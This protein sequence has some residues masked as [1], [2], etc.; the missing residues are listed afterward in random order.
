[1]QPYNGRIFKKALGG[2]KRMIYSGHQLSFFPWMGYWK[3]IYNSDF[4]DINI[5]DQFTKRTWIHYTFIGNKQQ[6]V[7]WK[8]PVEKF[9]TE[10]AEFFPIKEIRV[11]KGFAKDLL[12]QFYDVHHRDKYFEYIYP[13][14][15]EWL[16]SVEDL[17]SLWLIN[18]IMME[19]IYNLLQISSQLVILPNFDTRDDSSWKIVKQTLAMNCNTYLSGPHGKRYLNMEIF[20]EKGIQVQFHNTQELYNLYPQSIL[21]I[22]SEYGIAKTLEILRNKEI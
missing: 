2:R 20:R 4:F 9:Y 16:Y 5:Y 19:K 22:I 7:K 14:L 17:E 6:L 12:I 8:L 13:L 11:K 1:M 15:K 10:H 18:L 3:K 21:S